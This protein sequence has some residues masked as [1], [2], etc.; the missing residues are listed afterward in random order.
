MKEGGIYF[1]NERTKTLHIRGCCKY[2]QG[3]FSQDIQHFDTENEVLA[4]AGLSFRWCKECVEWREELIHK[5]I[6]EQEEQKK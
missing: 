4:H 3:N 6:S 2:S 5:A 1:Y